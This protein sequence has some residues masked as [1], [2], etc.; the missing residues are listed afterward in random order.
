[1][2]CEMLS[3]RGVGQLI[4]TIEDVRRILNPRLRI[5]G[6]LPTMYD[7]R[8]NHARAVLADV[9]GRYDLIVLEPPIPRSI[10][11]A[12]APAVGRSVLTTARSGRGAEAYRTL[13]RGMF[14]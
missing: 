1:L 8:T 2:Q 13:A 4:D 11:F 12:E 14:G 10:R 9:A 5:A 7:G 3:H 6:V